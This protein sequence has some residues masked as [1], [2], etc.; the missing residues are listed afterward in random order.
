MVFQQ[1]LV[2]LVVET[3][4]KVVTQVT[5][6]DQQVKMVILV[7]YLVEAMVEVVVVQVVL[8]IGVVEVLLKDLK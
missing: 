1:V 3:K 8:D 5:G 6:Q 4:N 2:Q 7:S